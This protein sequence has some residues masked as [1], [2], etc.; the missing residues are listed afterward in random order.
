MFSYIG[1]IVYDPF[2]GCGTTL[3]IAN[4]LNR[5][6]IGSEITQ[7]YCDLFYKSLTP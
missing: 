2:A 4:T 1:D 7:Q 6:W 5:Q 3:R